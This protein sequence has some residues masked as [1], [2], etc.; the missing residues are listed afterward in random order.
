M[1]ASREYCQSFAAN[2]QGYLTLK[3]AK[4]FTRMIAPLYNKRT[5]LFENEEEEV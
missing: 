2:V 3:N 1:A 5:D 4:P